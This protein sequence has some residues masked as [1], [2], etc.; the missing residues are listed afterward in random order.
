MFQICLK[1]YSQ[2]NGMFLF[3]LCYIFLSVCMSEGNIPIDH[4]FSKQPLAT[5]NW[6][7]K[8]TD[9]AKMSVNIFLPFRSTP[10]IVDFSYLTEK[11]HDFPILLLPSNFFIIY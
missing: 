9:Y 11:W 2:A 6:V 8:K 5:C 7:W 4:I 3:W 10:F 1:A